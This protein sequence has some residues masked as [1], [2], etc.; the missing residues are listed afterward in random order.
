MHFH[1]Q[2]A[3]A[4][5]D[6]PRKVSTVST[7]PGLLPASVRSWHSTRSTHNTAHGREVVTRK[8][9]AI[10]KVRWATA[11]DT[12][13]WPHTAT[14][15][16]LWLINSQCRNNNGP[17]SAFINLLD[18]MGKHR[19]MS[20]SGNRAKHPLLQSLPGPWVIFLFSF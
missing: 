7:Q 3:R 16:I 20:T 15:Y 5:L 9:H 6:F 10:F 4:E 17:H 2:T 13:A 1:Q 12:Q 14:L 18:H 19:L 11:R 8:Q